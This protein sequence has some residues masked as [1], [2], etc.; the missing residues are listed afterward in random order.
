[1]SFRW[2]SIKNPWEDNMAQTVLPFEDWWKFCERT[3]WIE[4]C[5]LS[6]FF[7]PYPG[8]RKPSKQ[9]DLRDVM[10]QAWTIR[11]TVFKWTIWF[12]RKIRVRTICTFTFWY[13]LASR[14]FP[15]AK[16]SVVCTE[17]PVGLKF[18]SSKWKI[19]FS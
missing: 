18:Y 14:A 17:F 3:I 9:R 5:C 2:K 1:M 19:H 15:K 6:W 11:F 13:S 4:P 7:V 8:F 12:I 10:V 16:Y